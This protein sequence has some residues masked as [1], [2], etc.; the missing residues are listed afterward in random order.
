MLHE[1]RGFSNEVLILDSGISYSAGSLHATLPTL[2][3]IDIRCYNILRY[4]LA[5]STVSLGT[6]IPIITPTLLTDLDSHHD[7]SYLDAAALVT[8]FGTSKTDMSI[9]DRL[10]CAVQELPNEISEDILLRCQP[11]IAL[12]IASHTRHSLFMSVIRKDIARK[13]IT[14]C[15][16]AGW[17][18]DSKTRQT[19]YTERIVTLSAHMK[20][21]FVCLGGEMYL[22]SIN[23]ESS[24]LEALDVFIEDGR[25]E[26][27]AL[28]V[29]HFGIRNIAFAL[30]NHRRPIWI[31][32]DTRIHKIFLDEKGEFERIRIV[33][34]VSTGDLLLNF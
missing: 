27:L 8:V 10:I 19:H 18:L 15:V 33:S 17:L 14:M 28:H 2:W 26:V 32:G 20:A 3:L 6:I 25:P 21:T 7:L 24:C 11:D 34:D 31:R 16:E 23:K 4:I 1:V 5:A 29:D 22:Q 12:A 13:R 30:D 9:T